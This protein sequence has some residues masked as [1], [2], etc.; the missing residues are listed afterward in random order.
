MATANDVFDDVG[1]LAALFGRDIPGP[2]LKFFVEVLLEHLTPD[3][4][5]AA[6]N[7][8]AARETRWPAPAHLIELMKPKLEARDEASELSQDL[9]SLIA[10]KGYTWESTCRYDGYESA[11]QGVELELGPHAA[12]I[13]RRCG[14]WAR[15]CKEWGGEEGSTS[16]RAQLR[17]M[18]ESA[19]K[20]EPSDFVPRGQIGSGPQLVGK[21]LMAGYVDTA[22]AQERDYEDEDIRDEG[23]E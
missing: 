8:W 3:E 9:L 6:I 5:R 17:G 22:I 14:G 13:V 2:A 23:D 15:F 19:L 1:K 10:S 20:R 11:E 7:R 21:L 4:A 12:A 18:C 16:L